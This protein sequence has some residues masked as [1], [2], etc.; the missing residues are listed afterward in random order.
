MAVTQKHTVALKASAHCPT[1]SKADIS[2]R[3]LNFAIDEPTERGGTNMG[4]TPTDAAIAALVGCTNVISNKCAKKLGIDIGQLTVNA[5]AQFDRRGVLLSEEIDVP[6]VSITLDITANGPATAEELAQ[7][8]EEAAKF[9]PL[10]KLFRQA[11][12]EV[13]ENWKSA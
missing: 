2:I 13:I 11:G 8:A 12:T 7:V 3:D 1:H 4:P 5:T 6:F 10:S 9:C